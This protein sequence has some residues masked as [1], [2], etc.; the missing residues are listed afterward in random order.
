MSERVRDT[1]IKENM[2]LYRSAQENCIPAPCTPD[3]TATL[4]NHYQAL[5]DDNPD[6]PEEYIAEMMLDDNHINGGLDGTNGES[7]PANT[8]QGRVHY[9]LSE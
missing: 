7:Y 4:D 9:L 1:F 6:L 5:N 8:D 2:P 3:Y